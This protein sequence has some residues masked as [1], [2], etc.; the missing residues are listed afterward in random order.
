M[1][2]PAPGTEIAGG[3]IRDGPGL[4]ADG[5]LWNNARPPGLGLSSNSRVLELPRARRRAS[6][7]DRL[8]AGGDDPEHV[9]G[10]DGEAAPAG[11]V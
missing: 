10:F 2:S 6:A 1:Y 3:L 7:A 8:G 9:A 11:P 5:L 4:T